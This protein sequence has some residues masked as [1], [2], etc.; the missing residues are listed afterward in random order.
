MET[1][2]FS[3]VDFD[4]GGIRRGGT[5]SEN[6]R[7]VCLIR[8]NGKLAIWGDGSSHQNID[9]VQAAG[10]P[11]EV[12]CECITPPDWARKHGHTYW[13]PQG[14]NLRVVKL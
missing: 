13:V 11:C 9:K 5:N 10:M 6:W 14:R 2:T 7:L 3:L 8:D 12:E 4:E 1:K